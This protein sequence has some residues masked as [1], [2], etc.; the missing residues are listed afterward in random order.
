VRAGLDVPGLGR[1]LLAFVFPCFLAAPLSVD[2]AGVLQ[3]GGFASSPLSEFAFFS[4]L[5]VGV[6][7]PTGGL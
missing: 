7:S 1:V 2:S 3:T 5:D 6:G 4:G